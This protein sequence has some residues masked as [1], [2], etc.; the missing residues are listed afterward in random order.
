VQNDEI[1]VPGISIGAAG[2][3]SATSQQRHSYT[4]VSWFRKT[5][6]LPV[7]W[8]VDTESGN[9]NTDTAATLA[10][11][12]GGVKSSALF[13][14]DG[15]PVGNHSGYMDGFELD[16]TP[17]LHRWLH[18]KHPHHQLR[19]QPL[20]QQQHV[21]LPA[22]TPTTITVT[23][24]VNGACQDAVLKLPTGC[25]CLTG[26]FDSIDL[27]DW[28]GI[29]GDVTLVHRTPLTIEQLT[30]Q[31]HGPLGARRDVA[32]V[33]ITAMLGNGAAVVDWWELAAGGATQLEV[34]I[35]EDDPDPNPN[36]RRL[37]QMKQFPLATVLLYPTSGAGADNGQSVNAAVHLTLDIA[38][39]NL[40][41]PDSP[42][43]YHADLRLIRTTPTTN[44]STTP[45]ITPST[46]L[47]ASA[48][49]TIITEAL[50]RAHVRF[51]LREIEIN[52]QYFMLNG[53]RHFLVGTGDDFAYDPTL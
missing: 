37:V 17:T 36:S 9:G 44:L 42:A 27:A 6:T 30:V 7:G 40:W 24:R 18:N 32:T 41:S 45:S 19:H 26:C 43:L 53:N 13:W 25:G 34:S 39:P 2:F 51:G 50:S 22:P 52:G 33:N 28:S 16:L 23:V 10:L 29:W 14:V 3:G 31:L 5:V 35:T 15:V 46:A 12:V 38:A 49:R 1:M 21:P 48:S 8:V 11:S 4:G 20:H 47:D